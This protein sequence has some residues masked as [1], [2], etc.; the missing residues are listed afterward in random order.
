MLISLVEIGPSLSLVVTPNVDVYAELR[1]QTGKL[2]GKN[3]VITGTLHSMSRDEA[4]DRIRT[5]GGTFQTAIAKDTDF[6]VVGEKVGASK[7]AKAKVY[8]TEVITEDD[9]LKLI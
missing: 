8:G 3:F 1:T 2:V 9:F 4:A 6:L 7:F 5:Q